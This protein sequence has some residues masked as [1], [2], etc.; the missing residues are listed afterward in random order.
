MNKWYLNLHED[1]ENDIV[2][3]TRIRLARNLE[4]FPFGDNIS[5]DDA[6]KLSELIKGAVT[7]INLGENALT[8]YA[9]IDLDDVTIKSLVEKHSV[10]P[11]FVT[12]RNASSLLL[13]ADES[14]SIMINE[15][16][17][18]RIQA[19]QSGLCLD[20]AL[21]IANKIDDV[22]DARV[23]Y[24]FDEKLGYLTT[25]PTN[26]GTGLRASV[27]L[28]LP[29]YERANMIPNLASMVSKLGLTIRGVFGEGSHQRGSIYQISNQITLGISESDAI[30]NLEGIVLQ[31]IKQE[32][33]M[34]KSQFDA[35]PAI[36]DAIYRG[37]GILKY[38]RR[39]SSQ[40]MYQLIS[41]LREGI[42]LG[43]FNKI[44]IA[45]INKLEFECGTAQLIK[46]LKID[47]NFNDN[48]KK[49]AC[50]DSRDELRASLIRELI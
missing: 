47:D 5:N 42:S 40:E 41:V 38:A 19:L 43:V 24:A 22:I 37:Y 36:E 4:Q 8:F 49:R 6:I 26:I 10:S 1:S 30:A 33:L 18:V 25:C 28:H 39:I 35:S 17:H 48:K 44:D 20:G 16:D 34:R 2:L 32:R 14:I 3:S 15:E 46:K 23:N 7:D 50:S 13:S 12:K 31:I 21:D 45:K 11:D 29:A 27:M 9:G